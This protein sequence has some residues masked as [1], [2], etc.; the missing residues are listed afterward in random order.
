MALQ[1]LEAN[2]A[3]VEQAKREWEITVDSLPQLICLLNHQQQIVRANRTVERWTGIPIVD[4]IGQLAC[5][6]LPIDQLDTFLDGSWPHLDGSRLF[7]TEV[8][9]SRTETHLNL[10]L[11]PISV[12]S[13]THGSLVA[14]IIADITVRKGMEA[15]LRE[16]NE[17]LE[18]RIVERTTALSEAVG[19]LKVEV[20]ERQ[21]IEADLRRRVA[22][23]HALHDISLQLKAQLDN[24]DLLNLMAEQ[25]K[26]LIDAHTTGVYLYQA[27]QDILVLE[28]ASGPHSMPLTIRPVEGVVGQAFQGQ[29]SILY[30]GWV[31]VSGSFVGTNTADAMLA[32]PLS[33]P[34]ATLGVLNIISNQ[35]ANFTADDRWLAELFAAQAAIALD[36][37]RLYKQERDQLRRLQESQAQL[38]QVEKMVALGRLVGSI[39]HE[40]NN[41]LQ[42]VQGFLSLL[43]EEL[44]GPQRPQKIT[45]YLNIAG[46]EIDRISGIVQRMRDFYGT[47][48]VLLESEGPDQFYHLDSTDLQYSDI[49]A[50]LEA[51]LEL[52]QKRLSQHQIEVQCTW[53]DDLPPIHG[54]VDYLKQVFLNLVLNASDAMAGKGGILHLETQA[55]TLK[56]RPAVRITVSDTGVGIASE[57]LPRL[58]EPLFTTKEY[59]TGFGLFTSYKIIEAH[60]GHISVQ[61]QVGQ[62]ATFTI[63]LPIEQDKAA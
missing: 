16:S 60:H 63:L 43:A 19:M 3:R 10:Q 9:D 45:N 56:Y 1:Q 15:I 7:E 50:I 22:T 40:I 54:N 17:L 20:N 39:A 6:L 28:A 48:P 4:V 31:G 55:S 49:H 53:A 35:Q 51:V 38:I 30:H 61:S 33:G 52:V 25:V 5:D 29:R 37:A 32:V 59:G 62:G 24:K 41:P 23:L 27:E 18:L 34:T 14:L 26:N 12:P 57:T 11:W 46:Q 47:K 2:L 21:R 58:F 8:W 44:A 42:S 13:Q 36:N